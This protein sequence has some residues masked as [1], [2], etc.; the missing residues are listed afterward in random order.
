VRNAGE[1]GGDRSGHTDRED[2]APEPVFDRCIF[3]GVTAATSPLLLN[4]GLDAGGGVISRS[5]ER[6]FLGVD[7]LLRK[8]N[9]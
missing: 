5:H 4:L 2:R 7:L 1:P 6:P 9:I 8:K 3:L